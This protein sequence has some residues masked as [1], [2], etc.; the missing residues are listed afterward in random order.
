VGD[1]NGKPISGVT[2]R[3]STSDDGVVYPREV[4]TDQDGRAASTWTLGSAGGTQHAHAS[5][6]RLPEVEFTAEADAPMI[7][8]LASAASITALTLT[9]PD[10]SGQTVHPDHVRMPV[11]WTPAGEYLAITPY[12]NGNTIFENPSLYAR[13]TDAAWTPPA[14]VQ[15]PLIT[16][17]NGGY[18]SDPD[19]V[20]VPERRELWIY[21][22][23]VADH[24]VIQVI[25]SADG[26]HFDNP[27]TVAEGE[28]HVIVSPSVVRRGPKDW[29]MWAINSRSG[30]NGE[31]TTVELRRSQDGLQWSA[32]EP[33]E[34][35]QDG[36][37]PWHI[38]VQWIP[39]RQEFWALYNVKT[40]GS[41]ATPALYLATSRDGKTWMTYPWPVL[42]RGTVPEF[43]EIVYRST[44]AYDS[45]TD[46]VRLWY[47]GARYDQGWVWSSAFQER[48]R[49]ELFASIMRPPTSALRAMLHRR[50]RRRLLD[51]P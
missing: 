47:S 45:A 49:S 37:F 30:C 29:L 28:N 22:R 13:R 1:A 25:R 4:T 38:D 41:C 39:S 14:G 9:T 48:S 2:V 15:N 32:P 10:G 11:D 5:V 27:L 17:T 18:L 44:F 26:S 12:P 21:Y 24:N 51:A 40:A 23:A 6:E 43:S 3:W 19:A 35:S 42:M 7:V 8:P 50:P 46:V 34:L 33:V 36:V 20:F 16:P 31:R